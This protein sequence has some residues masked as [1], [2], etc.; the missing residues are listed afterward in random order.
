M[1]NPYWELILLLT[2]I[3]VIFALSLN[4]IL[5]FNGQFAL[6]HAGFLAVGAYASGVL[7]S[8]FHWPLWAAVLCSIGLTIVFAAAIGYPCLRLRGDYLAIATLGFAEIIRIVLITLP[9]DIF[10]GPTGMQNVHKLGDYI[11]LPRSMNGVGNFAATVVLALL[12]AALV[13]W[14]A[15]TLGTFAARGLAQRL[16]GRAW[17]PRAAAALRLL[18]WLGCAGLA[19]LPALRKFVA[20]I[21]DFGSSF[22][23]VSFNNQQWVL[24]AIYG[25]LALVVLWMIRNYLGSSAGRGVVAIRE[26]EIAAQ[27]LGIDVA[28]LKL[29]NFMF[30]CGFAGLAGALLAYTVPLYRPQD[31][32]FFRSVDVLLM[33]VLGGMGSLTGSCL[34]AVCV[35]FLPE[36][37]RFL[38]QWRLVIYSLLLILLMLFRPSGLLGSAELSD[39]LR[40]RWPRRRGGPGGGSGTAA[41]AVDSGTSATAVDSLQATAPAPLGHAPAPPQTGASGA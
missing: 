5:G 39:V 12:A 32:G 7:T 8:V 16:A 25:L 28:W 40:L 19:A 17:A 4:L 41:S 31:F 36:V 3:N 20:G 13:V 33:V 30:A 37:L 2:L 11:A 6:G 24:F 35:T 9:A 26:D 34:G 21:F 15:A 23:T 29:Q 10:G 22:K 1:I 14:G 27:N 18:V 38:G